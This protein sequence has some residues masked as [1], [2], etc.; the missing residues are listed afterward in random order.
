[1]TDGP[2]PTALIDPA[3]F[4]ASLGHYPT[5]VAVVTAILDGRPVGFTVGSFGSVSLE[6]PLVGFLA[7]RTSTTWPEVR[8]AGAFCVNVLG[9]GG[10]EVCWQFSRPSDDRFASVEW[11]PAPSG[12]PVLRCASLWVD[13]TVDEV[14][15]AGDHLMVLGRVNALEVV[16][17]GRPLVFHRGRVLA[18]DGGDR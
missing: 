11:S 7:T 2:Q 18:L 12:A 1:M 3:D 14:L 9:A 5:G 6:P 10:E 15:P 4:R 17:A 8:A 16:S 13:C